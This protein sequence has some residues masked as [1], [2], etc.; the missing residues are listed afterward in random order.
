MN[1]RTRWVPPGPTLLFCP[2]SRPDRFTKAAR[3]ADGVILDLEDSVPPDSKTVA[4]QHVSEALKSGLLDPARTVVRINPLGSPAG[5]DDLAALATTPLR[6]VLVPKVEAPV[7][8]TDAAGLDVIALCETAAGIR[9]AGD[10]A[11]SPGCV[12]LAI[13]YEDLAAQLGAWTLGPDDGLGAVQTIRLHMR[14]AAAEG[15]V[16]VFDG[17]PTELCDEVSIEARARAAAALGFAGSLVVHPHQAGPVRR[18]FR[19]TPAQVRWAR[20]VLEAA[21]TTTSGSAVRRA[22]RMVD[23]PILQRAQAVLAFAEP[24]DHADQAGSL[25]SPHL[26][27]S[28][29]TRP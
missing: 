7:P 27:S 8:A 22:N 15:N 13:G 10:I 26:P 1:D 25:D 4:R 29:E 16:P 23:A 12:A 21:D 28:Q 14:M 17:P 20:G 24:D 6:A 11:T 2:G 19:P 18:G 5:H 3:V 9:H